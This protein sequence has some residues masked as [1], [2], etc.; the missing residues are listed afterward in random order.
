LSESTSKLGGYLSAWQPEKR[1][2]HRAGF[3]CRPQKCKLSAER[4]ESNNSNPKDENRDTSAS[5]SIEPEGEPKRVSLDPRVPDKTVIISQDLTLSEESE[6]LSF[7]DKNNDV[8]AWRT[9]DLMGV[10]R[11]IIEHKL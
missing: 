3:H 5:R 1:K 8:F 10:S 11:D 2:N 9:S 6:L 4:V 7:L